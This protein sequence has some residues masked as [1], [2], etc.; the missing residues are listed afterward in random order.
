MTCT[1]SQKMTYLVWKLNQE[2]NGRSTFEKDEKFYNE[3]KEW[4]K[5]EYRYKNPEPSLKEHN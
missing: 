5:N 4:L 3:Y 2:L 1:K